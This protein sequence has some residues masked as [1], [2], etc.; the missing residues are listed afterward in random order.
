MCGCLHVPVLQGKNSLCL[1]CVFLF[2]FFFY[3]TLFVCWAFF[4]SRF[5]IIDLLKKACCCYCDFEGIRILHPFESYC[6]G[7]MDFEKMALGRRTIDN[8]R[9]ISHG[10]LIACR[11]GTFGEDYIY[12]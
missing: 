11:R 7:A 6:G 1:S 2:L 4:Q 10:K 5:N 8:E 3:K 12:F 9:I